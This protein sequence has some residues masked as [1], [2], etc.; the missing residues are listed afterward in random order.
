MTVTPNSDSAPWDGG[1]RDPFSPQPPAQPQLEPARSRSGGRLRWLVALVA[2]LF[3]LA[4]V[5]VVFV[6]ANPP[7]APGGV[8]PLARFAPQGSV[9]YVEARL[10]LPGDQRDQVISFMSHFPGFSDPATF[11]QKVSDTLDQLM[12]ADQ[13]EVG[14]KSDI[15]PWFGGQLVA[16]V[17]SL[18]GAEGTPQAG[19]VALSVKDRAALDR[20]LDKELAARDYESSEYRGTTIWSGRIAEQRT[21]LA[22]TDDALL[23]S[24]RIEEMHAALDVAG[25]ERAGL[26]DDARFSDA[27]GKLSGDRLAGLYLDG[28]AMQEAMQDSMDSMGGMSMMTAPWTDQLQQFPDVVVGHLRAESD[29]MLLEMRS[30]PREGQPFPDLPQNRTSTLAAQFPT[31]V[32][33]YGE[34]RS[35]GQGI[36]SQLMQVLELYAGVGSDDVFPPEVEQLLGTRPEDFLD[37]VGDTAIAVSAE[38]DRYGGGLI[39]LVDDEDV[40]RQRL[41]RLVTS[42]RTMLAFAGPDIPLTIE[43]ETHAGVSVVVFRLRGD[44]PGMDDLPISSFSY[45]LADGRLLLG[46]DDFVTAALGRSEGDSLAGSAGFGRALSEAGESNGGFFYLNVGQLRQIIESEVPAGER[47][48]MAEFWPFFEHFSHIIST[49]VTDGDEMVTRFLLFVE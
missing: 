44:L 36:K 41:E 25:G 20:F 21:A 17:D 2:T 27:M 42:L 14:W 40:A 34:V 8:S 6:L 35:L 32:V 43:E 1:S 11:D 26:A 49:V 33:G 38:G 24:F 31:G 19:T 18:S 12:R 22:A 30:V 46:A 48:E 29:H 23:I 47:A 28:Q 15:E 10:D 5:A 39:A 9:A 13:T 7:A 37:F 4:T 16:F 3:V 45:A